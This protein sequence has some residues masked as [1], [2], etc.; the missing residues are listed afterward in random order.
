LCRRRC[1]RVDVDT[2]HRPRSG[3]RGG[4]ADE[5]GCAAQVDDIAAGYQLR[6]IE[7][8]AG[9]CLPARPGER[10]ERQGPEDH[11]VHKAHDQRRF[12]RG[13]AGQGLQPAV[14]LQRIR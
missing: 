13:R 9:K 3:K 2:K 1:H 7:Q 10:P 8:P 6:M 11:A 12:G 4:D 14:D 5:T